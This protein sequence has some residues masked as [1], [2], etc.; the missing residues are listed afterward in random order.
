MEMSKIVNFELLLQVILVALVTGLISFP[1]IY[2]RQNASEVIR[3][4]F[5]QCGPEDNND[6]W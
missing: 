3:T 1:N 6:L 4:L 2:T 5:S